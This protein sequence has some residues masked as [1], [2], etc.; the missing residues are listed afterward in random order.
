MFCDE[1]NLKFTEV[2]VGDVILSRRGATAKNLALQLT[3][4]E[5][6]RPTASE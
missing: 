1:H 2:L 4:Q 5:I 3:E 6:L